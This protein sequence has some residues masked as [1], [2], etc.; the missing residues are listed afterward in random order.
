MCTHP[1][2]ALKTR[3]YSGKDNSH[4]VFCELDSV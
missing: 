3:D 2:F 1:N 4:S